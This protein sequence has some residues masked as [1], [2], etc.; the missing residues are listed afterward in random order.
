MSDGTILE[1]VSRGKK[2]A[3]QIQD[4]QRTWFGSPY[5]RRS[6]STREFR[7]LYPE[8]PPRFGQWFDIIIPPDGD[9]LMSFDLRITMPTWLPPSIA[10]LNTQPHAYAVQV[11]SQPYELLDRKS[12]V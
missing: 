4:P 12:V 6:P 8:N 11:E 1:L 10:V 3:Y 2:D 5:E 9:V 7:R